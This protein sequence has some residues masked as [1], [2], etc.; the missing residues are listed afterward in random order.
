MVRHLLGPDNV[1]KTHFHEADGDGPLSEAIYIQTLGVNAKDARFIEQHQASLRRV[2]ISLG[3]PWSKLDA[4]GRT[5]ENADAEDEW[6]WNS[7]IMP[8]ADKLSEEVNASL[9]PRLGSEVGWFDLSGIRA[10]RGRPPVDAQGAAA[11]VQAGIA[12]AEELR[13]WYGLTGPAP[14]PRPSSPCP[15]R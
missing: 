13:A 3:V 12:S 11:L 5:Y 8:L 14:S 2:A 10:L 15:T 9:A 1:N 7:T 6:F 4:S